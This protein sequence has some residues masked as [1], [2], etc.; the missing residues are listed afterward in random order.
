MPHAKN[1]KKKKKKSLLLQRE[2]SGSFYYVFLIGSR[3]VR[4]I[5]FYKDVKKPPRLYAET[6]V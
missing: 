1:K 5:S 3:A 4:N 6:L 2:R